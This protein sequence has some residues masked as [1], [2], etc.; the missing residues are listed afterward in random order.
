MASITAGTWLS[1]AMAL[2]STAASYHSA[3][4]QQQS[5]DKARRTQE[6]QIAE[7]TAAANAEKTR[8]ENIE[9]ERLERLRKKGAGLPPSLLTGM[10][11]V[12]GAGSTTGPILGA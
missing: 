10:S 6:K 8:L 7:A 12:T 9:T 5:A 3:H 11:G 4:K 1:A 2:G